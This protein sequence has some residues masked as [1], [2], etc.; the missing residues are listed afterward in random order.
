MTIHREGEPE[1]FDVTIIRAKIV[2][3]SIDSRMLENNLGYI[4]ILTFGQDTRDELTDNLERI[5]D[6]NPDGLVVDLRNNGGGYSQTAVEVASEFISNNVILYEDYGPDQNLDEYQA[7]KG[8][9]ASEIPLVL[10]V[11]EGSASASEIVAGAIQ[12]HERGP[13][14]ERPPSEKVLSRTGSNSQIIRVL[15]V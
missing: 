14:W 9:L 4:Q 11:N 15:S 6:Q 12:D 2:V 3:P 7:M 8:G 13:P 5:L 10:L 1:L